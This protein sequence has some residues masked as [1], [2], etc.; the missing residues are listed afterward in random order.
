MYPT[1]R[2]LSS[3]CQ[4]EDALALLFPSTD[5]THHK[6]TEKIN[7]RLLLN[8]T[9]TIDGKMYVVDINETVRVIL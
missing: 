7:Y 6:T 2:E 9:C 1:A 3:F 5:G 8:L 4:N